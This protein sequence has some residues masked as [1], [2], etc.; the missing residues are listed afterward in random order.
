[1]TKPA[2]P[3]SGIGLR[4]PILLVI[5][6]FMVG[7][8]WVY[9]QNLEN[10]VPK[11]D[12]KF[13]KK[14]KESENEKKEEQSNLEILSEMIVGKQGPSKEMEEL[15]KA[16]EEDV[17]FTLAQIEAMDKAALEKNIA[18]LQARLEKKRSSLPPSFAAGAFGGGDDK[19]EEKEE[20]VD[21]ATIQGIA[22]PLEVMRQL[23]EDK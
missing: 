17:V 3:K 15:K 8:V 20:D 13:Y 5:G 21:T 18:A 22:L 23:L 11:G 4:L 2:S 19:K 14:P 12:P 1:M 6:V 7:G 9:L 10:S 16:K